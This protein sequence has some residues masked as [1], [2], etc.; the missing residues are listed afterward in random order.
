MMTLS[1]K[2]SEGKPIPFWKGWLFTLTVGAVVGAYVG[3]LVL[4]AQAVAVAPWGS[5]INPLLI[6]LRAFRYLPAAILFCLAVG[7]I[8]IN[9]CYT[10]IR[11]FIPDAMGTAWKRLVV[12]L[13]IGTG[14]NV[15]L[16]LFY[17]PQTA[18]HTADWSLHGLTSFPYPE[19]EIAAPLVL[20]LCRRRWFGNA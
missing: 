14:W 15:A 16:L 20:L 10:V 8:P 2:A 17:P 6:P 5:E 18:A 9:L 11:R 13:A 1:Q 4:Q 19:V 7:I 3:L 12:G